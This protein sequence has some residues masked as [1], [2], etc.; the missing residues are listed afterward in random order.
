[1]QLQ[2]AREIYSIK[3][4]HL[5]L[6]VPETKRIRGARGEKP[7]EIYCKLVQQTLIRL[8]YGIFL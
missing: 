5:L 7:E 3:S 2:Q 1:L 4:V 6:N 8:S